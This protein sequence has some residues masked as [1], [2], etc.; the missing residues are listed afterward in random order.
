MNLIRTIFRNFYW[1]I[2]FV[3]ETVADVFGFHGR[4]TN[5]SVDSLLSQADRNPVATQNICA[6]VLVGGGLFFGTEVTIALRRGRVGIVTWGM[7][8][9]AI[10][11]ADFY[12]KN[13]P[14]A[15][16]ILVSIYG[17]I[18]LFSLVTGIQLFRGHLLFGG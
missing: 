14:I 8:G 5:V 1:W 15:F 9:Y 11:T 13:E 10:K 3:L 6:G 16:W 4:S 7:S 17:A 18:G 12:R 2:K